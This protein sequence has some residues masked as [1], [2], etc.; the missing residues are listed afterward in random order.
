MGG[1]RYDVTDQSLCPLSPV[2]EVGEFR[3]ARRDD[4]EATIEELAIIR[5]IFLPEQEWRA[6]TSH[7][8]PPP[9]EALSLLRRR[10]RGQI[11]DRFPQRARS[12]AERPAEDLRY[13][14]P[15]LRHR[16]LSQR[17]EGIWAGVHKSRRG[18]QVRGRSSFL[19]FS[20]CRKQMTRGIIV[21]LRWQFTPFPRE[22]S[23]AREAAN[24]TKGLVCEN[25]FV[26][27]TLWFE[28][29]TRVPP[30]GGIYKMYYCSS[31]RL[32]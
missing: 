1:F 29:L 2:A 16:D 15:L 31:T 19:Q 14:V 13:S 20:C 21:I 9:T 11:Q 30:Y 5:T 12:V 22:V 24:T 23:Q 28:S 18:A 6:S 25:K 26:C 10:L 32:N 27:M 17:P 3:S 4:A 7:A 8:S